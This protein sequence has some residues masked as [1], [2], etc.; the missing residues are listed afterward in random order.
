MPLYAIAVFTCA[1][2]DYTLPSKNA[3]K[4]SQLEARAALALGNEAMTPFA[5]TKHL[6]M[7]LIICAH[8]GGNEWL[9]RP[10]AHPTC[11]LAVLRS[12]WRR[13]WPNYLGGVYIA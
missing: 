8:M 11:T 12:Q 7:R 2:A 3:I 13:M 4:A 6:R 1:D 5:A 9:P 10:G